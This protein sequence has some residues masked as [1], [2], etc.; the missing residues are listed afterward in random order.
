MAR[1]HD[2]YASPFPHCNRLPGHFGGYC[3]NCKWPDRSASC[4]KRD[5]VEN[6]WGRVAERISY[7]AAAAPLALP[8][9]GSREADPIEVKDEAD[10]DD[11]MD[12]V[13]NLYDGS[14]GAGTAEDPLQLD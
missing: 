12:L 4:S 13:P 1:D 8:A 3:G 10:D 2:S 6:T 7:E 9:G 14:A 5:E 11:E